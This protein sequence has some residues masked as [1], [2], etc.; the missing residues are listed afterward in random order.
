MVNAG[1]QLAILRRLAV[2]RCSALTRVKRRAPGR[3]IATKP[4]NAISANAATTA[5]AIGSDV[6][7][8]TNASTSGAIA[9]IIMYG[10]AIRPIR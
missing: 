4:T 3:R 8:A 9:C 5:S 6:R 2:I 7:S 10:S 1:L